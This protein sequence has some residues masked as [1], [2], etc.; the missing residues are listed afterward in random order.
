MLRQAGPEDLAAITALMNENIRN[1]TAV[2]H[3]EERRLEDVTR[4]YDD[5]Q[6]R[7]HPLFV[8]EEAGVFLGYGTFGP[9]R[10]HDGY[11]RT[12]EHS[13]YVDKNHQGKGAGGALLE[14]L[15]EAAQRDGYHAMVAYID[16][17]NQQSIRLHERKGF[18]NCG[19]LR[20][21]GYKFGRYLDLV[22]MERLLLEE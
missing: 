16:A 6:R 21:V 12:V 18:Q 2:Y 13:V 15:I 8:A 4:W 7:K 3:Y 14:A 19:R 9:Y 11:A 17:E 22:I 1:S 5:K 10:P 20:E